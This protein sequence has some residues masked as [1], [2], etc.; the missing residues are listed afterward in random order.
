MDWINCCNR[1]DTAQTYR[2]EEEVGQGIKESGEKV[3][4]TTKWSG[5]DNKSIRESI[6]D[7]LTKVCYYFFPPHLEVLMMKEL[8]RGLRE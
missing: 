5:T 2:N 4:L 3:W 8:I 1:I 7:S 6:N